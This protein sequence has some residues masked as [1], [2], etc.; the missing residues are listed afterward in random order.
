MCKSAFEFTLFLRRGRSCCFTSLAAIGMWPSVFWKHTLNAEKPPQKAVFPS[1]VV[2]D[3]RLELPAWWSQTTRATNCANPGF[4]GIQFCFNC[5]QTCGHG[6]FLTTSTCGGSACIA[7][8]SRDCGHGIFR[9]EG[10]ATRSQ[11]YVWTFSEDSCVLFGAFRRSCGSFLKLFCPVCFSH[12][13]R[14]LGFVWDGIL[15]IKSA[16]DRVYIQQRVLFAAE[17]SSETAPHKQRNKRWRDITHP[18][19]KRKMCC[20]R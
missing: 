16:S 14:L 13:F 4:L 7:D 2:R 3:G 8:V 15:Y 12:R 1:K 9:L 18:L 19:D 10:G 5:G 17:S 20:G 6:D 11:T